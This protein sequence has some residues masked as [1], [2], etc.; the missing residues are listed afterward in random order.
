MPA[1]ISAGVFDALA[2]LDPEDGSFHPPGTEGVLHHGF[3]RDRLARQ[4]TDAGFVDVELDRV[5]GAP[6][7]RRS[8]RPSTSAQTLDARATTVVLPSSYCGLT[9]ALLSSYCRITIILLSYYFALDLD[10]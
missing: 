9:I 3:D 2:E 1:Q 8:G 10:V 6:R 5:R 7:R 4:L